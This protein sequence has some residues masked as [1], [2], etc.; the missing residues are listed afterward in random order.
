MQGPTHITAGIALEKL[1]QPL[2]PKAFR[3]IALAI[4]ALLMHS[5]FDRIAIMTYHPPNADLHDPFWVGYHVPVYLAFLIMAIYFIPRYPI[6]VSF[7]IL[8]DLDWVFIHGA[9]ALGIKDP[10]Y[11]EAYLHKG[12]HFVIDH[13]PPFSLLHQYLPDYRHQP[14]TILIEVGLIVLM[15]LLI[16]WLNTR[17]KFRTA[18]ELRRSRQK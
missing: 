14:W 9:S 17:P 11:D 6:G 13:L 10:W 16:R 7:S 3:F 4:T 15:V 8:P 18:R 12:V 5:V 2:K 1:F